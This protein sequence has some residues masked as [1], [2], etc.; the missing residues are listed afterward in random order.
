[1]RRRDKNV[2]ISLIF[3]ASI[4]RIIPVP[5]RHQR[6]KKNSGAR[7]KKPHF[8]YFFVEKSAKE[9]VGGNYYF[10]VCTL[11]LTRNPKRGR[12]HL[13]VMHFFVSHMSSPSF[14]FLFL[15]CRGKESVYASKKK[16]ERGTYYNIFSSQSQLLSRL[17]SDDLIAWTKRE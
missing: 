8:Y 7:K 1:M 11:L 2:I 4:S 6:S 17:L 10:F 9:G 14:L 5:P 13:F 16:I 12:Q 3:T 15:F